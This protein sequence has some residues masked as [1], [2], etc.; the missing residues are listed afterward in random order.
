MAKALNE[1]ASDRK[2]TP[3]QLALAW[4]LSKGDHIIPIPGTRHRKYLEENAGAADIVL[5]D[6][7]IKAIEDLLLR[8]PNIG[9]RYTENFAKQVDKE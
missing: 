8:F 9:S 1:L 4:V 3:A 6:D 5:N 7:E 2:C